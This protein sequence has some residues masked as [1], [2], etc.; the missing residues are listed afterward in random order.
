M[1]PND[2]KKIVLITKSNLYEGNMMPFGMKNATNTLSHIMVD[3]FKKWTS[4]FLKVFVDNSDIHKSTWVEHMHHIRL[5][6]QKLAEV[7][8]IKLNPR[9]C[10]FEYK[11]ITGTCGELY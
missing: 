5:V 10:C 2:V 8:L 4:Q 7:N 9:K 1:A 6:P 11:N 3:I